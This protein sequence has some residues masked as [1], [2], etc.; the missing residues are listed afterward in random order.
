MFESQFE[1]FLGEGSQ[2]SIRQ[3]RH[4]IGAGVAPQVDGNSEERVGLEQ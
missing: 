1:S 4:T 2:P 3:V